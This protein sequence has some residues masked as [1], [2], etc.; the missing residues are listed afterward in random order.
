MFHTFTLALSLACV[1]CPIWLF[2]VLP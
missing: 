1:Q 2:F